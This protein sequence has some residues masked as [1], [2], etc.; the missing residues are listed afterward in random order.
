M[1]KQPQKVRK[2][3]EK[4]LGPTKREKN[5]EDYGSTVKLSPFTRMGKYKEFYEH[6]YVEEFY[7]NCSV[8]N[9][10]ILSLRKKLEIR[11]YYA[12][13][14]SVSRFNCYEKM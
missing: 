14:H 4:S 1:L 6:S 13:H 12:I 5:K 3:S 2:I 9:E 10:K 11:E 8:S 7:V